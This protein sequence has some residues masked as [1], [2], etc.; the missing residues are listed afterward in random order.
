MSK[1]FTP[2]PVLAALPGTWVVG[3][4]VRDLLLGLA[5]GDFDV[6]VEGDAVA[7]A[8]RAAASLGGEV[9]VHERFGTATVRAGDLAFDVAGARR[10]TYARPG[11]LPDVELG[12]TLEDDLA[13]RDFTVN[14]LALRLRDGELAGWP[15]AEDDLRARVLRV[16][17]DASFTDDPTRLIRLARYAGR[18]GLAAD[19]HTARLAATAVASGAL[20]TVSGERL[21]AEVRLLA[22]EPQPAALLA[23]EAHGLGAALLPAFAVDAALVERVVAV[24]AEVAAGSAGGG[25]DAAAGGAAVRDG[26]QPPAAA[27]RSDVVALACAVRG[28]DGREL[29]AR[30]R[31]LG[32][33]AAEAAAIVG[34]AGVDAAALARMRPSEADAV[35][36][37][38][39]VEAAAVAA[40]AGAEPAR[41]W[42]LR[43]R[44]ARLAIRGDDLLAAGLSGPAVGRGLAAARAALLDGVAG[45][46]GAQLAAA[47]AGAG[48]RRRRQ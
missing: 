12:A 45:D 28:A 15:G 21:G 47:L 19:A 46:R 34:A 31:A 11:A 18:L 33:P 27:P 41:A 8:R 1:L 39:P 24:C 48:E 38:L 23:L 14:T 37:R 26:G 32:F 2:A 16:L 4:A 29:A 6:V 22:R 42:L 43:D 44:H 25:G 17:H 5:P 30:L 9:V 35:L 36:A 3:G 13:R 7:V 10:E 40:A 20:T